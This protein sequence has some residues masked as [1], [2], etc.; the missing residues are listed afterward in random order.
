MFKGYWIA[1][2]RFM[3]WHIV[4]GA[5]WA[6]VLLLV[7][8]AP[9]RGKALLCNRAWAT[10][11]L[12]SY[13]IYL[14]HLPLLARLLAALNHWLPGRFMGWHR[15]T[16]LAVPFL[17]AACIAAA[18]LTYRFIERPFLRRKRRLGALSAPP[19]AR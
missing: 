10:I 14:L 1:E 6:T 19:G 9:L 17:S 13:S 15:A 11:G 2:S 5:L 18:A 3:A 7:L 16:V 12:L 8:L 4:E